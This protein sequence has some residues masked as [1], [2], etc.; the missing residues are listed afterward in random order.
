MPN[1]RMYNI[2]PHF[3]PDARVHNCLNDKGN[4]SFRLVTF[5]ILTTAEITSLRENLRFS[6]ISDSSIPS[7]S[8]SLTPKVHIA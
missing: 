4:S 6:R 3:S 1:Y 2:S 8:R 7:S 5:I